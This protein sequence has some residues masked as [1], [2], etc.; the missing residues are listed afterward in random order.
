MTTQFC[1]M[2]KSVHKNRWNVIVFNFDPLSAV[3][4]CVAP[5]H[6]DCAPTETPVFQVC[7]NLNKPL[8]VTEAACQ[9]NRTYV[10]FN[11]SF[12]LNLVTVL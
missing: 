2:C 8:K 10:L 5:V 6:K 4:V 1:N 11:A 9:A 12:T 3:S 7:P